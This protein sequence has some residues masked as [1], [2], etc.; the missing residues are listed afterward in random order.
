[1]TN[2]VRTV[3]HGS[4]KIFFFSPFAGFEEDDLLKVADIIFNSCGT[5]QAP[6]PKNF[7]DELDKEYY[8]D[9]FKEATYIKGR[10]SL[11]FRFIIREPLDNAARWNVMV[12]DIKHGISWS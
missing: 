9:R 12:W 1:M 3:K 4:G 6:C 11:V 10:R 8:C 5:K 2:R 7:P